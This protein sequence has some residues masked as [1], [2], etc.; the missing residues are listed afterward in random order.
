MN[1]FVS[2]MSE[3]LKDKNLAVVFLGVF[4]GF[5]RVLN[6]KDTS[7]RKFIAGICTSGFVSILTAMALSDF[8]IPFSLKGFFIG[9]AGYSGTVTLDIFTKY[10]IKRLQKITDEK[11]IRENKENKKVNE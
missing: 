2:W 5:V 7:Y 8:D 4:G 9:I 11:E 10:F 6:D 1:D 3:Q